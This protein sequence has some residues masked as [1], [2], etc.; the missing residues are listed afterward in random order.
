VRDDVGP[1]LD[2][3]PAGVGESIAHRGGGYTGARARP[4]G[5]ASVHAKSPP[6][7]A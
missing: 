7:R 6:T 1:E 5:P 4:S 2:D 3:D